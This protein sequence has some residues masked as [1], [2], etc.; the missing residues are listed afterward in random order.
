MPDFAID[1]ALEL[2]DIFFKGDFLNKSNLFD[3]AF[4]ILDGHLESYPDS[5]RNKNIQKTHLREL[6]ERLLLFL[7]KKEVPVESDIDTLYRFGILLSEYIWPFLTGNTL[8]EKEIREKYDEFLSNSLSFIVRYLPDHK[9]GEKSLEQ[10]K[11]L[12]KQESFNHFLQLYSQ[13][14]EKLSGLKCESE[15]RV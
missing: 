5:D 7:E 3:E 13:E 14:K 11:K 12:T 10:F 9:Y 8:L 6:I 2:L 1:N 4:D 15:N